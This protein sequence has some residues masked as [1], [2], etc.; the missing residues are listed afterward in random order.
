MPSDLIMG[1]ATGFGVEELRVLLTSAATHAPSADVLL[2]TDRA[3]PD[4]QERLRKL[5]PRVRLAQI[6]DAARR[7][8]AWRSA[9]SRRRLR[10]LGPLKSVSLQLSLSTPWP[11]L[12]LAALHSTCA[13]HFWHLDAIR[14]G[15][16]RDARRILLVD[17]RDVL[18]QADPFETAPAADRLLIGAEPRLIAPSLFPYKLTR[19]LYGAKTADRMIGHYFL[20]AG[21]CLGSPEILERYLEATTRVMRRHGRHL[22]GRFLDQPLHCKVLLADGCVPFEATTEGNPWLTHLLF[23]D[24]PLFRLTEDAL[25]TMEGRPVSIVH[26]YDRVPLLAQWVERK[27]GKG[28]LVASGGKIE[29]PLTFPGDFGYDPPL[30]G[31]EPRNRTSGEIPASGPVNGDLER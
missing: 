12:G 1:A 8:R 24:R 5:N 25:T 18:F 14:K 28:R 20:C 29:N 4:F 10:T 26:R 3:T 17:T 30:G 31:G 22:F 27:Y 11:N 7:Q 2:L 19:R 21:V 15:L 9:H 16:T 23:I 6:P 13:R